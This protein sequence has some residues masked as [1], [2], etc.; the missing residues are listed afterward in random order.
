MKLLLTSSGI[1]NKSI[2]KAVTDLVG[3]SAEDI[4]VVF[5]PTAANVEGGEKL[6]LINDL[7]NFKNQGYKSIDIIDIAAVAKNIWLPRLEKADLICFGGGNEQFLAKVMRES[8]FSDVAQELLQSR[9]YMGISAGSMVAGQFLSKKLLNVVYP[10]DAFEGELEKPLGIANL[11]F[12]PHLNSEWFQ[13]V[14]KDIISSLKP[15]LSYPLYALDDN[16]ALQITDGEIKV[17]SEGEY[18]KV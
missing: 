11:N 13:N 8:G 3:R 4:N 9:V 15:E 10:E 1:T 2:A 6:W 14:R 7:L 18:L 5:V 12:L 16:S 17:V